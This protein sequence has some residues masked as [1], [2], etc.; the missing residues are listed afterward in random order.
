MLSRLPRWFVTQFQ[1]GREVK[2]VLGKYR[3]DTL[4]LKSVLKRFG[5]LGRLKR[6]AILGLMTARS[7]GLNLLPQQSP[8]P[9]HQTAEAGNLCP[10]LWHSCKMRKE[11][12]E[13][14]QMIVS[15]GVFQR[16]ERD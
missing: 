14:E 15:G 6:A 5:N 2:S 16:I 7:S 9:F 1:F 8:L 12:Q 4:F 11:S 13:L 3:G 10:L